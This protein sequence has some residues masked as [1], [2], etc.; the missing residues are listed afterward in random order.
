[1]LFEHYVHFH[2]LNYG[3]VTEW[4]PIGKYLLTRPTICFI[5]ISAKYQFSFFPL[6][7]WSENFFLT[8]LFPDHCLLFTSYRGTEGHSY[9]RTKVRTYGRLE[10]L[11][12]SL[13]R[14]GTISRGTTLSLPEA[15]L[16]TNTI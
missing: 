13:K 4:Q 9:R 12:I 6:G 14:R 2:I 11:R 15:V 10:S 1:M 8:A 3:P 7:F 16:L 5:S